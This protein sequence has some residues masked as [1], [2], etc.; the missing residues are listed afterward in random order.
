MEEYQLLALTVYHSETPRSSGKSSST[1]SGL[2][3][4]REPEKRV[5]ANKR[6]GSGLS[7]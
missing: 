2:L 3:M 5:G 7:V 1:Y 6:V 4:R